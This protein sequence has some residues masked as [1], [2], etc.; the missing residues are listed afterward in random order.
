MS[1]DNASTSLAAVDE[2]F[3][4]H[5]DLYK[6]VLGVKSNASPEQ[7]QRAYFDRRNELLQ[8]LADMAEEEQD[9][10]TASHRFH[11]ERKMAA[12]VLAMRILG[13]PELRLEYDDL[14]AE[15]LLG[16]QSP[17]R[18]PEMSVNQRKSALRPEQRYQSFPPKVELPRDKR[19][20]RV[21]P[22]SSVREKR[23]ERREGL[24]SATLESTLD[25]DGLDMTDEGTVL[26]EGSTMSEGTLTTVKKGFVDRVKDE[27]LGALDDTTTSFHQVFHVFTL[28]DEDIRAVTGRISKAK[29]QMERSL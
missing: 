13:E 6:D 20:N 26:S 9:S 17:V 10:I 1:F 23:V 21:T 8:L 18:S 12:V 29:R 27:V 25:Y 14:R 22:E 11:A 7:I 16:R 4:S 2:A 5:S 28:Q 15:R 24:D 19:T 3:G